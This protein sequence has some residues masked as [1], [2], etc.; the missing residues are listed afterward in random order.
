LSLIS[1]STY[2]ICLPPA[3]RGH[4]YDICFDI[5]QKG[6]L[7]FSAMDKSTGNKNDIKITNV[8]GRLSTEE[9]ER[10]IQE[11]EAFCIADKKFLKKAEVMNALD[12]CEVVMNALLLHN[13]MLSNE[14]NKR[15][16]K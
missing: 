2:Y 8:K 15:I 12:Y 10:L 3:A 13:L 14:T 11:A 5:D 4:P 16:L 9:I 6:I 7:T 1:I